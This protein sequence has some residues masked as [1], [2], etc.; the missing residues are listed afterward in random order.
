MIVALTAFPAKRARTMTFLFVSLGFGVLVGASYALLNVRSSAPPI[1]VLL[2]LLGVL[3]G[4]QI[5]AIARWA[6][7]RLRVIGA[8]SR[9]PVSSEPRRPSGLPGI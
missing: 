9:G 5:V 7:G 3:I 1:V 8:A 2:A 4:E 6:L